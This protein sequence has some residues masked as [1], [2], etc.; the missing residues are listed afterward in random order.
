MHVAVHSLAAAH[1]SR[2]QDRVYGPVMTLAVVAAQIA[3]VGM[4][5]ID[6]GVRWN[7]LA[8]ELDDDHAF[9]EQQHG[10]GPPRFH[11]QLVFE[12]GGAPREVGIHT[13]HF[14]D[15]PLELRHRVAP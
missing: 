6:V 1:P 11:G 2:H 5:L 3:R 15:L 10:V 13:D 8:L 7:Q 9:A 14:A 4:C 12:D